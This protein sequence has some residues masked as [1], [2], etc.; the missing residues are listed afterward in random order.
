MVPSQG[1]SNPDVDSVSLQLRVTGVVD[2][3][4]A[5]KALTEIFWLGTI[6]PAGSGETRSVITELALPVLD[7]SS[8]SS[9]RKSAIMEIGLPA[10]V[11]DTVA[12]D[13]SWRSA[14]FAPLF[15]VFAG[16]LLVT[17]HDVALVGR[18]APPFGQIGLLI[19]RGLLHVVARRTA[20]ALLGRFAD[21]FS[22]AG[23]ASSGA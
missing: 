3:S 1:P 11:G 4:E 13:I 14:S 22:Q 2:I 23:Q 12:A 5:T 10:S 16:R 9:I 21:R 6:G 17:D 15:P 19:D 18:Y 7:G 8:G 20:L